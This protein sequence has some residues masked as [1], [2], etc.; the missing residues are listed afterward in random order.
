MKRRK[1]KAMIPKPSH[2]EMLQ[3]QGMAFADSVRQIGTAPRTRSD[4]RVPMD[5]N[6]QPRKSSSDE[7]A[8]DQSGELIDA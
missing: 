7:P 8:A 4:R 1:P 6:R 3:S 5:G 2:V